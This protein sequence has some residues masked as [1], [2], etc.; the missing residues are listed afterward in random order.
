LEGLEERALLSGVTSDDGSAADVL[1]AAATTTTPV[2][3][4]RYT[5]PQGKRVVITLFGNGT[6][7]G[8]TVN[9]SGA[10]NLVFAGTNS[11]TG[12]VG[13]VIGGGDVPLRSIRHAGLSQQSLSGVGNSLLNVVNLKDF[14]L[15]AGGRI[16]LTGG[17]HTFIL[18]SIGPNTQV[19][20]RELA[21]S[22]QSGGSS[23]SSST[24]STTSTFTAPITSTQNNVTVTIATDSN[25]GQSISNVSGQF[26]PGTNLPQLTV[27][28]KPGLHLAPLGIIAVVNHINGPARTNTGLGDAQI[29]GYDSTKNDLIA[30][31]V[32]SGNPTLTIP[33]ALPAGGVEAGV[34]LARNAGKL[35]VLVS[36]GTNVYAYNAV[37]GAAAGQFSTASLA[38]AGLTNP[39]RLGSYDAATAIGDPS[40]GTNGLIQPI[41]V[42]ASLSSGSAVAIG[43]PYASQ[44]AF[45]LSGGMSGVAGLNTLFAAGGAH[46]DTFQ[47]AQFQLGVAALSP[48]ST[49]T[50]REASRTAVTSSI[51]VNKP[52]DAHGGT[53]TS[54][55]DALGSID[56]NLALV[57][58]VA[59]GANTVTIY[60]PQSLAAQ[61]TPVTLN[62]PNRLTD[63]S[64]TFRPALA[65]SA[66]FDVQGNIQ[67]FRA[68]DAQ[69]LVL[70][71]LGNLNLLKI[72]NATDSTIV[73]Y[74]FGHAIMP[75]RSNVLIE[76]S[77]RTVDGRNGV[78]VVPNIKPTGPLSLP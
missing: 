61:V 28:G 3:S 48:S 42:T 8:T 32:V 51:G 11:Q 16:N 50:L 29:F 64:A 71:D 25:G 59:N 13:K 40:A 58:G 77:T 47:P 45:G 65:G 26:S 23:T 43:S 76:S 27:S 18:N 34:T 74:P 6:L 10:L 7:A 9:S 2:K 4:F 63:L 1:Q 12:I 68:Q 5:T 30:F 38:A 67:S 62:D 69:G 46:F 15:V 49:G 39:T 73:G 36:N 17:V 52:S 21:E 54:P 72:D 22:L 20:L 75:Q 33:N 78:T 19:N 55:N 24:S 57:T 53:A 66:L 56:Q 31:D 14:D 70:S 37:T 35:V 41:D 44:R 60:S